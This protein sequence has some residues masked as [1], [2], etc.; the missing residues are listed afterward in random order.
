MRYLLLTLTLWILTAISL[1]TQAETVIG[2]HTGQS[3]IDDSQ[4]QQV[5][6]A[7][8][9]K[10]GQSR[11]TVNSG[12]LKREEASGIA[13]SSV[14]MT[15]L[16][17]PSLLKHWWDIKLK[18]KLPTADEQQAL[19]TGSFDQEIRLQAIRQYRLTSSDTLLHWMYT[20][21]RNRGH[22][23]RYRLQ[24]SFKWGTGLQYQGISLAYD[25][26]EGSQQSSDIQH[27][28]AIYY[29]KKFSGL[30]VSPYLQKRVLQK[31]VEGQQPEQWGAGVSV[32]F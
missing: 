29:Q 19:G 9:W 21:Y 26:R 28:L 4:W 14:S 1:V 31:E 12:W 13:D 5:S 18:L 32:K 22:S 16:F 8:K 23:D 2:L 7:Y 6:L 24:N 17:K 20:G 25:G 15:W 10:I 27:Y 11:W 30:S 3:K